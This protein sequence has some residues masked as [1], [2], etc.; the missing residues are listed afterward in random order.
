MLE[1]G[2]E[3]EADKKHAVRIWEELGMDEKTKGRDCPI[4]KADDQ[5]VDGED[6]TEL[7]KEEASKFRRIAATANFLALDRTDIQYA[8]KE[9]CRDMSRPMM[10]S[11]GK[12]KR[13]A[14]YLIK[15]PRM[16]WKYPEVEEHEVE[17]LDAYTDSDWAGCLG[18]RKSTNGGV[19]A[20]WGKC[21]QV[22]EQYA[23]HGGI[24]ERRSG[25]LRISEDR[26]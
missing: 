20:L 13:I 25:V 24:V 10:K 2:I 14:R 11:W 26:S 4:S 12:L 19:L 22:M 7:S 23:V 8:V 16:V 17:V 6:E 21:N 18:T 1:D 15:H 9:I 3:Y 5:N